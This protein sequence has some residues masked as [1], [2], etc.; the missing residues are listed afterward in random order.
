MA[1]SILLVEDDWM[2]RGGLKELFEQSKA[3]KMS[4]FYNDYSN[5]VRDIPLCSEWI[6]DRTTACGV[7]ELGQGDNLTPGMPYDEAV[8][9]KNGTKIY[10]CH[11][12]AP[13]S[14]SE[15][16]YFSLCSIITVSQKLCN[17]KNIALYIYRI[18]IGNTVFSLP[19]QS[20]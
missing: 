19:R 2:L 16:V 20:T 9:S 6:T 4:L 14:N 7:E 8:P 11:Y 3:V 13:S 12:S 17:G 15:T 10:E 5:G 18:K 1:F